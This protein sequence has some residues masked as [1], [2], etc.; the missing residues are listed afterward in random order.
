MADYFIDVLLDEGR[1]EAIKNAGLG[2]NIKYRFAGELKLVEVHVSE[3]TKNKVLQEFDTA[4][5]DSRNAITD[6]PVAFLRELYNQVVEKKSLG[7][8]AVEAVLAKSAE[9]KELAAKESE[10]LPAPEID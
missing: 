9:I 5:T 8:D 1:L 2:D 3:D 6:V 7:D 4:R 10:Y